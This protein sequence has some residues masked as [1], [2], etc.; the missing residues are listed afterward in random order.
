MSS[1]ALD[2]KLEEQNFLSCS[3][4]DHPDPSSIASR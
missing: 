1:E 4:F 3:S 2:E